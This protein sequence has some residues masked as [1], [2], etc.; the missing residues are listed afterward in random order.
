AGGVGVSLNVLG[1]GVPDGELVLDV[2]KRAVEDPE[3]A[4]D[5]PRVED[6]DDELDVRGREEPEVAGVGGERNRLAGARVVLE[7]LP[8]DLDL[9]TAAREA[10][11]GGRGAARRGQGARRP[12]QEQDRM[13]P[14]TLHWASLHLTCA[15]RP[16]S[17]SGAARETLSV[18]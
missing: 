13:D 10:Q 14:R 11:R 5:D 3:L 2:R 7:V 18:V 1:L 17:G 12:E 9:E 4:V 6:L 15:N 8:G 16:G